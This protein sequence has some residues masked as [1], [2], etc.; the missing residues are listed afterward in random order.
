MV[1]AMDNSAPDLL[2]LGLLPCEE[3]RG[4]HPRIQM[5]GSQ[6]DPRPCTGL[7]LR[8][9][10]GLGARAG[11]VDFYWKY[12]QSTQLGHFW[13]GL[14]LSCLHPGPLCPL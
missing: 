12:G 14:S 5:R 2:P 13:A 1:G 11:T 4:A 9:S 7:G 3:V 6:D 8:L 10:V